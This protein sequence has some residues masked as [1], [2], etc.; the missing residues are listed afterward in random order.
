MIQ[1]KF[2]T[3]TLGCPDIEKSQGLESVKL[4]EISTQAVKCD[5]LSSDFKIQS[6]IN[7]STL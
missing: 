4:S 1:D 6:L 7:K 5:F 3:P 2:E